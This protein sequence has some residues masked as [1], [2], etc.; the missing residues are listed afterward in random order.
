MSKPRNLRVY[1]SEEDIDSAIDA[2]HADP[3]STVT[4][5]E[6]LGMTTAE[7]AA[8]V[9]QGAV[10]ACLLSTNLEET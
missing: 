10:P 4:L 6:Y 3:P 8:Y 9:E 2:W 1:G 5:A 7:Y